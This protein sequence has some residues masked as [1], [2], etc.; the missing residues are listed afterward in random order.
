MEAT[1][2]R[3]PRP[4]TA[5]DVRSLRRWLIVAGVWAVAATAIAA[6]ALI[7]ANRADD[8]DNAARRTSGQIGAVQRD[9]NGRIDKLEQ[10]I[11]GLPTSEDL[12]KLD[13]RLKRVEDGASKTSGDLDR[14]RTQLDDLKSRVDDLES[15]AGA[16]TNTNTTT[17]P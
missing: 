2:P 16:N 6:I 3:R 10:R 17:T 15:S 14:L 7:V 4:A 5:E 11:D 9:L 12:A 13:G 8:N 1:P